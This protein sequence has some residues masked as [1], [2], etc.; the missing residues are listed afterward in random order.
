M[1]K[2]KPS[3]CILQKECKAMISNPAWDEEAFCYK[4]GWS[5]KTMSEDEQKAMIEKL[6]QV[7]L[8]ENDKEDITFG[9]YHLCPTCKKPIKNGECCNTCD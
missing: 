2:T 7:G 8:M 6:S 1:T 3:H 5:K 9:G 4:C